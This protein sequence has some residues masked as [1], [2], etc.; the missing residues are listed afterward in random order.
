M[1]GG[2]V[3]IP[4]WTASLLLLAVFGAVACGGGGSDDD[5]SES[6]VAEFPTA[7][8]PAELPQPIIVSGTPRP[9]GGDDTY[10]VQDGDT[11]AAIASQFSVSVDELMTLNGIDDP[12]SLIPGQELIIP[13]ASDA[14]PTPEPQDEPTAA[15]TEPPVEEEPVEEPTEA[16]SE[17]TYVVQDGD[18][19]ASIAEQFGISVEALMDA[20][21]ITD[22]SS[23]HIGD[24]LVI[25]APE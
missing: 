19:P 18:F 22:P 23:L 8:F 4:L 10:V 9:A 1:P 25:P 16:P 14:G 7:T 6:V 3:R 12:G 17:Q 21:G 11:L 24:V 20:N 13:G 2:R 5:N 15:P